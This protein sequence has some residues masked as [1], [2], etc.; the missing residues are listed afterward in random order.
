MAAE[1]DET[2]K[3]VEAGGASDAPTAAPSNSAVVKRVQQNRL[4]CNL[5]NEMMGFTE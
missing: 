1:P 3:T 4:V 5:F 2:T